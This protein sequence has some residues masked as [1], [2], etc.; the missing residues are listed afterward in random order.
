MQQSV[1]AA[2]TPS[3]QGLQVGSGRGC[4]LLKALQTPALAVQYGAAACQRPANETAMQLASPAK[5]PP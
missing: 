2:V 5:P 1:A 3:R 4:L